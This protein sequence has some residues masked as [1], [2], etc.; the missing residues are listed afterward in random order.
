MIIWGQEEQIFALCIM[1][2]LQLWGGGVLSEA[3]TTTAHLRSNLTAP[4]LSRCIIVSYYNAN[5]LLRPIKMSK[6]NAMQTVISSFCSR[7]TCV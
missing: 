4:S 2:Q 1:H 6:Q 7:Y 5:F 3:V